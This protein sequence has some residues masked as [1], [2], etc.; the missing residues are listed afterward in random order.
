MHLKRVF[1]RTVVLS[2]CVVFILPACKKKRAFKEESGQSAEDVRMAQGQNDE[3]IKDVNIAI[4]EQ[5][6]LRGRPASPGS[7][8]SATSELCGV[9]IDT[10]SVYQGITRLKYLGTSCSG[11]VKSGSIVISIENYPTNKWKNR[12]TVL[13]MEFIAYKV[14]LPNGKSVQFDGTAY[15]KNESGNTWYEMRYLNAGNIIQD[16]TADNIKITY[17]GNNTALFN[18]NRRLTFSYSGGVSSCS[19]EGLGYFNGV[20]N[21]DNWGQT[22]NGDDF[23]SEVQS[24]LVWKS[25]CG[26]SNPVTGVLNI[27][28]EDKPF[29]LKAEFGVDQSG[30]P[31][32]GGSCP[33]GWKV[34]WSYKKKESSRILPYN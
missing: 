23:T 5:S 7:V 34:S 25:Y 24:P 32:D 26:S 10:T 30:S 28:V 18:F 12:N 6:L 31:S 11:L 19:V 22:R 4:M 15:I 16:Q 3:A 29:D 1:V 2:L 33:Y 27:K 20:S 14:I 8:S 21:L 13:K 17:D 9:Q